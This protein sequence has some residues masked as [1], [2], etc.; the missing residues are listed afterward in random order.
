[1]GEYYNWV[2]VEKKNIFV[3]QILTLETSLEKQCMFLKVA[4]ME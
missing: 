4:E 2:N 1:M 3:R